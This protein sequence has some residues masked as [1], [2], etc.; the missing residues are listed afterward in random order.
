[1]P[2]TS[3]EPDN[4]VFQD[5]KPALMESRAELMAGLQMDQKRVNPKYFYDERGSEMF[6]QI[7]Q[8]QEYYPTRTEMAI[9]GEYATEIAE[10]CGNDCVLIEPGSGNSEKVRLLL[11][12]VQ[13][14]AYV[15]VDISAEFLYESAVRLGREF[16]WLNIHAIC[17][18]FSEQWQDR[19]ELP[20]G[21]RIV[22]YPGSTIG[23]M[24]PKAAEAFLSDLRQWIGSDGGV[25]IGVDLHKSETLLNAAYNDASGVTAEFN[26]NILSSVNELVDGD[27]SEEAFSHHAFYNT[28]LK[29]IEMHLVSKESQTVK[30]NGSKIQFDKG[31]TL[32]TENT[33]KYSQ[34]DF[35]ELSDAAG[36][37]LGKSWLEKNEL[38]S[39][40]YLTVA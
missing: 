6:E 14:A 7:T 30:V 24:E 25:L 38:F 31:E 2:A 39:V 1:M 28:E 29:R 21:R 13:P 33:Y 37:V 35:S 19:T 15:P 34:Q 27:F 8:Q 36:L 26:L 4:V 23:N 12:S 5:Q 22:F 32:H 20:D 10:H 17:A 9:L 3:T 11:D 40:H 18:D 16:P